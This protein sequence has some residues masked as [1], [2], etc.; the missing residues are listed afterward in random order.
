MESFYK[1][2]KNI[3]KTKLTARKGCMREGSR[4]LTKANTLRGGQS[5]ARGRIF[6]CI[7]VTFWPPFGIILAPF[8]YLLAPFGYR[9]APCLIA[10]VPFGYLLAPFWYHLAQFC[11]PRRFY[12]IPAH[13]WSIRQNTIPYIGAE[14]LL[15]Q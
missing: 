13:M 11:L 2:K 12:R 6:R 7:L 4:T 9:L 15:L 14:I 3:A 8:G 1:K 10:L 5:P